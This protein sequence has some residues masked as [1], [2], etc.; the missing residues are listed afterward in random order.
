MLL[1]NKTKTEGNEHF[2]FF[3]FLSSYIKKG[4]LD[5]VTGY[6]SVSTIARMKDEIN[7]P[8]CFRMI[9]GNI[10]KEETHEDK[11]IDLFSDSLSIN[12]VLQLGLSAKKAVDFLKQDEVLSRSPQMSSLFSFPFPVKNPRPNL[13]FQ[14]P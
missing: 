9:P 6:F 10:L 8:E 1:D 7:G 4:K 11:I 14:G 5:I 12:Q 2:R 13:P 3:D